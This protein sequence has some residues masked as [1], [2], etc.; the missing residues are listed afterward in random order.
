MIIKTDY[1]TEIKVIVSGI[2]RFDAEGIW[3]EKL[4]FSFFITDALAMEW[5]TVE[6][7]NND[8]MEELFKYYGRTLNNKFNEFD[9]EWYCEDTKEYT[10]DIFFCDIVNTLTYNYYFKVA[11]V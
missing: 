5:D 2:D 11:G 7:A 8:I 3:K 4:H 10:H 9:I 1:M 6:Q